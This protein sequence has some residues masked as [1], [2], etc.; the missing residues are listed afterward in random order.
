MPTLGG[1]GAERVVCN[2][3]NNLDPQKYDVNI[4]LLMQADHVYVPLLASH[5]NVIY[6]G[7][8]KQL[9]YCAFFVLRSI[10]KEKPDIVFLG[11]G[12]LNA[13]ISPFISFFKGIKWIARETNTVSVYTP[14]KIARF[15]VRKFYNNFHV[16]IAQ[17]NDMK[18]DLV[19]NFQTNPNKIKIIN[20][21]VDTGSIAIALQ[22]NSSDA[23]VHFNNGKINLVACGRL[24]NQKGFDLLLREF[25]SLSN[26]EKY[27]LTIIGRNQDDYLDY[28]DKI[29]SEQNIQNK[30][31]I[32]PF[33]N[34]IHAWLKE[35]DI[36]VLS[37]RFE[38]FP[39]ILLE[40]IYCGVPVLANHCPGGITEI[41][42]Q[43]NGEVFSFAK[44]ADFEDKLN[45][46]QNTHYTKEKLQDSIK[47][48]YGIEKKMDEYNE[49]FSLCMTNKI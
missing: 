16:I 5:V 44:E 13:L 20:N 1:G 3:A 9:R 40:A 10:R 30:V 8:R 29:I 33:K 2:V 39:N 19:N 36:F 15:F 11:S 28:L 18:N 46:I 4:L 6:G 12:N 27:H 47:Q 21:P 23:Q 7:L 35:A 34:D 25:A 14:S 43:D 26:I 37:S 17:C 38:G 22:H 32:L 42:T 45:K 24:S 31:S 49:V 48:R 41:V